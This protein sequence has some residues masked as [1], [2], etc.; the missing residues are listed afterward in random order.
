TYKA[1]YPITGIEGYPAAHTARA[2]GVEG[3]VDDQGRVAKIAVVPKPYQR[4]HP[5]L[6][7][8]TTK[9]RESVEFCA[10]RGFHPT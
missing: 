9:S 5:P 4:P 2:A 1:P 6:F 8:A 7:V 3:E 10:R